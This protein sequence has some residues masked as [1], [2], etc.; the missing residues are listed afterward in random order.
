MFPRILFSRRCCQGG[1]RRDFHVRFGGCSEAA[2][3]G[4]ASD[5]LS[6]VPPSLPPTPGPGVR[7]AP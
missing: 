2:T 4:S 1:S 7:S 3:A 6:L 5:L